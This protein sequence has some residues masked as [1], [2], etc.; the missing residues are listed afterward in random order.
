M[1]ILAVYRQQQL[2]EPMRVL[3]HAEDICS[4][5]AAVGV[6]WWQLPMPAGLSADEEALRRHFEPRV[7][8]LMLEQGY[9][10][11]EIVNKP[12]LPGYLEAAEVVAESWH[13]HP[14]E[15]LRLFM[16]GG[17]VLSMLAGSEIFSLGC[18][19]GDVVKLPAGMVHSFRGRPGQDCMLICLM[20]GM[21][22]VKRL[23][24][25]PVSGFRPLDI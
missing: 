19:P 3:T 21:E 22:G 14:Q 9:R 1:S 8:Q 23:D 18:Q 6:S 15:G 4:Q 17:G 5:L 20:P 7:E 13:S 24:A 25:Q 11:A 2:Q 10:H 12:A 16:R